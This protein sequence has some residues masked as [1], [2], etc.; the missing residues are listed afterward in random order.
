MLFQ[1]TNRSKIWKLCETR[2]DKYEIL[3]LLVITWVF[4]IDPVYYTKHKGDRVDAESSRPSGKIAPP[5]LDI[6]PLSISF[7]KGANSAEIYGGSRF[8][9]H[10]SQFM[11]HI[12]YDQPISRRYRVVRIDFTQP[13]MVLALSFCFITILLA[14]FWSAISYVCSCEHLL[15]SILYFPVSSASSLRSAALLTICL[16]LLACHSQRAF[17]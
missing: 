5:Q 6:F 7:R 10:G 12:N 16:G 2:F 15:P 1:E 11:V 8:T 4:R 14:G 9:V 17:E 3:L 13:Q